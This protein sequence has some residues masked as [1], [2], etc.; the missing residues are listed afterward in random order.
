MVAPLNWGSVARR[1]AQSVRYA[2]SFLVFFSSELGDTGS[3]PNRLALARAASTHYAADDLEAFIGRIDTTIT[4]GAWLKTHP[5]E[6][7]SDS[8]PYHTEI[9]EVCR[10]ARS[11]VSIS[12]RTATRWAVFTIPRPTPEEMLPEGGPDVAERACHLRALWLVAE[13]PDSVRASTFAGS[14]ARLSR[15][16]WKDQRPRSVA[17][18][19]TTVGSRT[20]MG[21]SRRT[22]V[23][24]S[25]WC[26]MDH[27]P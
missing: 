12:G 23:L 10:T 21:W 4:L 3:N 24:E 18:R 15:P 1:F 26:K 25:F 7:V 14:L 8:I 17:D 19:A 22:V 20:H 16:G 5:N 9:E 11:T 27:A 13:E 2:L 6:V